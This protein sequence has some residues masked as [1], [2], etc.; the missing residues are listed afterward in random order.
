[1]VPGVA[2]LSG[3]ASSG[4]R[5]PGHLR[6]RPSPRAL[7][8]TPPTTDCVLAS[9]SPRAT[10]GGA[11]RAARSRGASS[12]RPLASE[13]GVA[14]PAMG[15]SGVDAGGH[16]AAVGRATNLC[17]V[18]PPAKGSSSCHSPPAI[19]PRRPRRCSV[20]AKIVS[21]HCCPT[22][23]C[24]SVC[25]R[26]VIHRRIH[27]LVNLEANLRHRLERFD[28]SEI[29][30]VHGKAC[31]LLGALALYRGQTESVGWANFAFGRGDEE[32]VEAVV[33][34]GLS[35]DPQRAHHWLLEARAA[36]HPV[37]SVNGQVPS[38]CSFGSN[39]L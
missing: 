2:A 29:D 31:N 25:V 14:S 26:A 23:T 16:A 28:C 21:P 34:D 3:V 32:L 30:A 13:R 33:R 24:E 18:L 27:T 8:P 20:T 37:P 35:G 1:M 7:T 4:R 15:V 19:R 10:W 39:H 17:L 38:P 6:L 9:A 12:R 36:L 11:G 22:S 5:R